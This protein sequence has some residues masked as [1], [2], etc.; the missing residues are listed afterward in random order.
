MS[1]RE[2]TIRD[3]LAAVGE[4]GKRVDA[5]GEAIGELREELGE[6]RV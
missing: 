5:N 2:P 4:V 3:V 1:E 6:V